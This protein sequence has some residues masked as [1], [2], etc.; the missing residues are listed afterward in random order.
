MLTHDEDL[1]QVNLGWHPRA[2]DLLWQPELQR[3]NAPRTAPPTSATATP[4][5]P[6]PCTPCA[7][8]SAPM[9]RGCGCVTRSETYGRSPCGDKDPSLSHGPLP[10][11]VRALQATPAQHEGAD[12]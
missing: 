6:R 1:H 8:S 7:D 2:E 4:S 5:K 10:H 12:R 3:G 11:K 9:C